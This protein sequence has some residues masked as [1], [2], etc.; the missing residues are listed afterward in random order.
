MYIGGGE[1]V[2]ILMDKHAIIKLKL[3]GHSNRKLEKMIN[4]NRKT[5]AK[6][7][8]EY[9]NQ[10]KLL[11][12]TGADNKEIQEKICSEPVYDS[13]NRKSRKYTPEMDQFLDEILEDEKEKCKVLGTNKQ[14][15]T[16][17]Q[18]YELV[19]NEGFEISQSTITNKIREKR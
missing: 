14:Q 18:I 1:G 19:V 7:W 8:N 12:S 15:L 11:S 13:S 6:Y 17:L 9:K 16:Q 2:I 10:M 5:I 3:E 4:I